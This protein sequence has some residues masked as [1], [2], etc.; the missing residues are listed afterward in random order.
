[1]AVND[2]FY[3][4]GTEELARIGNRM[5]GGGDLAF[6]ARMKQ[7][8]NVVHNCGGQQGLVC[9]HV[10]NDGLRLESKQTGGLGQAI[11]AAFMSL[12]S[13][14]RFDAIGPAGA[15]DLVVIGRDH[16]ARGTARSCVA[17]DPNDHWHTANVR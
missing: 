9:L 11:S 6:S 5:R 4:V 13:Q 2:D 16:Y 1:L 12:G 10:D 3:D 15:A 17:R 14:Y 7:L 8:R